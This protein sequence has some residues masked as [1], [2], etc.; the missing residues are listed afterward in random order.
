MLLHHGYASTGCRASGVLGDFRMTLAF[1]RTRRKL[2][3]LRLSSIFISY[4]YRCSERATTLLHDAVEFHQRPSGFR[5]SLCILLSPP[6][7]SSGSRDLSTSITPNSHH[8]R[9]NDTWSR[10]RNISTSRF[11]SM[12]HILT[13]C[14]MPLDVELLTFPHNTTN[15]KPLKLKKRKKTKK[16]S[17][18]H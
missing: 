3:L 13:P 6:R 8:P 1:W 14:L 12:W 15:S 9:A 18:E 7:F 5:S 4:S 16:Q 17:E 10:Y 11:I 2:N